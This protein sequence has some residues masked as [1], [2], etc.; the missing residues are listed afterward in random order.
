MHLAFSLLT[1]SPGAVGGSETYARGLLGAFAE[2]HG[3]GAR[4]RAR[5]PGSGGHNSAG[6]SRGGAGRRAE[7]RG[8]RLD[9]P[10]RPGAGDGNVRHER[11]RRAAPSTHGARAAHPRDVRDHSARPAAP[12]APVHVQPRG[13]PL[14]P[15][16]LRARC[17]QR[18]PRCHGLRAF[19]AADRRASRDR[20]RIGRCHPLRRG[21]RA[22]YPGRAAGCSARRPL[23]AL[24]GEHLAAQESRAPDRSSREGGGHRACPHRRALATTRLARGARRAPRGRAAPSG[25]RG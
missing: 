7:R 6:W 19:P 15:R 4:E 12:R 20:A 1:L 10:R 25:L 22:L 8:G 16:G 2:G 18:H 23:R 5:E 13:A 17:A 3:P 24:P 14:P 21:P 9:P 11:R